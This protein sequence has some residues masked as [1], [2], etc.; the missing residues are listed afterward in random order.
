[1]KMKNIYIIVMRNIY[2]VLSIFLFA[3]CINNQK[4]E[5][6]EEPLCIKNLNI[7]TLWSVNDLLGL[8]HEPEFVDRG[9]FIPLS[10]IDRLSDHPDSLAIP[11]FVSPV[12]WGNHRHFSDF[13]DEELR[14][15]S[16][17]MLER[18]FLVLGVEYRKRFLERTNISEADSVFVYCYATDVLLALPVKE[19]NVAAVSRWKPNTSQ[20]DFRFGFEINSDDLIGFEEV[21]DSWRILGK[22]LVYIGKTHPFARDGMR[23]IRW[24]RVPV[25]NFPLE[26]SNLDTDDETILYFMKYGIIDD[27]GFQYEFEQFMIFVQTLSDPTDRLRSAKRLLIIDTE[28]E[29][30]VTERV[31]YLSSV[32]RPTSLNFGIQSG[33]HNNDK[34]QWVG[35]LF[36][37]T[38][39]VAL[40]FW[41]EWLQNPSN[42]CPFI[43][44]LDAEIDDVY[45]KC[46]NRR[47]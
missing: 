25:E 32:G 37:N 20:Y 11:E 22:L 23:A 30:I 19:L 33:R 28:T 6:I 17:A 27:W 24:S 35:Y 1:M 43:M 14:L 12:D 34:N 40:G 5:N 16:S 46:D 47:W 2:I 4:K 39:P 10:D 7:F 3:S 31:I 36:R 9:F 41:E 42:L 8:W 15:L 29:N 21:S 44:F 45:I 13:S 26:K 18:E 38:P